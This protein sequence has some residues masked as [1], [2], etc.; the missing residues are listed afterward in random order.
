MAD[1]PALFQ[2]DIDEGVARARATGK[3]EGLANAG[4]TDSLIILLLTRKHTFRN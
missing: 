1:W 2:P 3:R 4:A